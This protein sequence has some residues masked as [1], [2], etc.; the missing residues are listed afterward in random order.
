MNKIKITSVEIAKNEVSVSNTHMGQVTAPEIPFSTSTRTAIPE[1]FA[2]IVLKMNIAHTKDS[3]SIAANA[4]YDVKQLEL[5][6]YENSFFTVVFLKVKDGIYPETLLPSFGIP[7]IDRTL[8]YNDTDIATRSLV[9]KMEAGNLEIIAL[10]LPLMVDYNSAH[11]SA[12]L[13]ALNTLGGIKS[14]KNELADTA[15]KELVTSYEATKKLIAIMRAEEDLFYLDLKDGTL[16][17]ALRK[18]GV[19]FEEEKTETL[20]AIKSKMTLTGADAIAPTWHVGKVLT[21]RG[22]VFKEGVTRTATTHGE[23]VLPTVQDGDLLLTGTCP[24]C[25]KITKTITLVSG[26]NQSLTFLFTLLPPEA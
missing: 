7:A 14:T 2:D 26:E 13:G 24:G 15:D 11:A 8:P 6:N 4:A 25:Y 12:L 17:D 16:N 20:I 23:V 10:G 18:W 21:K 9:A 1:R 22:K 5:Q 19:V 3:E